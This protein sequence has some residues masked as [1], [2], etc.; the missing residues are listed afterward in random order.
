MTSWQKRSATGTAPSKWLPL[1][2]QSISDR[3]P[4]SVWKRTLAGCIRCQ[5]PVGVRRLP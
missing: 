1:S 2:Y 3:S 5:R 4:A